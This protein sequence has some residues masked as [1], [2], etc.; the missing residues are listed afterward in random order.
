MTTHGLRGAF[1]RTPKFKLLYERMKRMETEQPFI[2]I[3]ATR[4]FLLGKNGALCYGTDNKPF[5]MRSTQITT[6]HCLRKEIEIIKARILLGSYDAD[7]LE[8]LESWSE[9]GISVLEG[10]CTIC[11]Q[12]IAK[13][14]SQDNRLN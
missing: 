9:E 11:D 7:D 6:E 4:P 1:I 3:A 2:E 13:E 12:H 10:A 14:L 8:F 5:L